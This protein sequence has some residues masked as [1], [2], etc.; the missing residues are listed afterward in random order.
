MTTPPPHPVRLRE[1]LILLGASGMLVAVDQWT[2]YL[3]RTRLEFGEVWAPIP[4]LGEWLRIVHWNNT[5]AAFGLFPSGG[6]VF[7]LIALVV[8]GAILYYYPRLPAGQAP[9][10]IAL[11]LQLGGAIGNLIDRLIQGTVT[12]FVAVAT[13]P[14]FNVADASIS[15]GVAVLAA[16]IWLEERRARHAEP[17]DP[18]PAAIG[19]DDPQDPPRT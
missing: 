7:T 11:A 14:V 15:V 10:R 13:F 1:Y 5:G 18:V 19:G 12:D 4:A 9:L 17:A 16:A 6:L 8:S 3:V 2:K